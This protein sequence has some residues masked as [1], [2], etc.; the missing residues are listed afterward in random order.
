MSDLTLE[1]L[2]AELK[3]IR[4]ELAF[5]SA[6]LVVMGGAIDVLQRDVRMTRAAVNDFAKTNVTSVKLKFLH[7]D[8]QRVMAK[9]DN[10]KRACWC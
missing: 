10:L 1:M 9:Q 5:I 8:L 6:R 7:E 4:S 3:P 2:R